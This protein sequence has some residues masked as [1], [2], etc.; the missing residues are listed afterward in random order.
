MEPF[1]WRSCDGRRTLRRRPAI[2]AP[3]PREATAMRPVDGS[4]IQPATV[5]PWRTS[6]TITAKMGNPAAKFA[7]PSSGS[8]TQT[9]S[10]PAKSPRS[11][12]S[13]ATAS[14]PRTTDPGIRSGSD[15]VNRR[16]LARSTEVT[17]SPGAF[18]PMSSGS[19]VAKC[20]IIS[21]AATSRM[22]AETRSMSGS[23]RVATDLSFGCE[24]APLEPRAIGGVDTHFEMSIAVLIAPGENLAVFVQPRERGSVLQ[25]HGVPN[26]FIAGGQQRVDLPHQLVASLARRG[27]SR[28]DVGI[29]F[30]E[31]HELHSLLCPQQVDLV[32]HLDPRARFVPG[33][34]IG[35]AH[36]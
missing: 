33:H 8:R 29:R 27:G 34:E 9:G 30:S 35:S 1:I 6:A 25:R 23:M 7:V 36:V 26:D 13:A 32:E 4:Y 11:A 14:S 5:S 16:S 20:G 24:E 15:C 3:S 17:K 31:A 10:F 18:S 28:G 2:Q 21:S 19:S 22:S 12:L